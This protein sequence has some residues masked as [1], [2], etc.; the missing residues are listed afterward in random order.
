MKPRTRHRVR[1]GLTIAA[2]CVLAVGAASC[3]WGVW[4]QH[5]DGNYREFGISLVRATVYTTYS[6]R[7]APSR[8]SRLPRQGW[9][10]AAKRAAGSPVVNFPASFQQQAAPPSWAVRAPLWIPLLTL[11]A[12]AGW[13]WWKH[14]KRSLHACEQ[15]GYDLSGTPGRACPECGRTSVS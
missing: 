11:A 10:W 7:S 14:A 2:T 6:D 8:M 1:W 9:R 13:M 15:C 3:V 12:P 4:V 5:D